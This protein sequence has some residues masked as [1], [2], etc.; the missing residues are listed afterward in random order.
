MQDHCLNGF[1]SLILYTFL[2]STSLSYRELTA[3]TFNI[4]TYN[5]SGDQFSEITSVA[6]L[7]LLVKN[8]SQLHL[9][10]DVIGRSVISSHSR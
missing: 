5:Q 3:E 9:M 6:G 4:R 2:S 7:H 10:H 8:L 1:R